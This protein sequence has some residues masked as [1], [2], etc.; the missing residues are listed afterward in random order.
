MTMTLVPA[1]AF[2]LIA[3]CANAAFSQPQVPGAARS[4]APVN[5]AVSVADFAPFLAQFKA[6]LERRDA[7][8]LLALTSDN[9]REFAIEG[10][11]AFA[12]RRDLRN[13]ASPFWQQTAELLSD[14]SRVERC[15]GSERACTI[16]YPN[17]VGLREV[18]SSIELR[19]FV[20]RR[21]GAALRDAPRD[22]ARV[23]RRLSHQQVTDTNG[24]LDVPVVASGEW[25]YVTLSDGTTGYV[26]GADLH[27][28]AGGLRI[29]FERDRSGMWKLRRY[30]EG[31]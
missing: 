15:E 19:Q 5:E 21:Q 7:N 14:G 24:G 12:R 3:G 17:W 22:N 11:Q 2:A 29:S 9:I 10:K 28:L 6:A 31:D 18:D 16:A 8:A 25:V 4:V 26:R 13:P 30:V 1:I 27:R 23:L 20:V